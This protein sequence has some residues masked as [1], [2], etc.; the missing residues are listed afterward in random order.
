MGPRRP[1]W[2]TDGRSV[3]IVLGYRDAQQEEGN[4]SLTKYHGHGINYSF[5]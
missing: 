1:L 3:G 5:K 4:N 2:Q